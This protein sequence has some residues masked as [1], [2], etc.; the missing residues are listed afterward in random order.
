M[1]EWF[2]T[3]FSKWEKKQSDIVYEGKNDCITSYIERE[4]EKYR[5]IWQLSTIKNM[6]EMKWNWMEWIHNCGTIIITK[7]NRM[8]EW[9]NETK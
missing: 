9:I 8:N 7:N 3:T 6:N 4:W 2:L 5:T 1:N